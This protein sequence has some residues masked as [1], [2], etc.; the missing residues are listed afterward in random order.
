MVILMVEPL[1]TRA[2]PWFLGGSSGVLPEIIYI[3]FQRLE[4]DTRRSTA[5]SVRHP[6]MLELTWDPWGTDLVDEPDEQ[7]DEFLLLLLTD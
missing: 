4:R 1:H 3:A 6:N 5:P 2:T 7:C